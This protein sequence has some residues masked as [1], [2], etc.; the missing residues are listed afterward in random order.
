MT[1]PEEDAQRLL[2]LLE[3]QHDFPGPFMF[4]VIH[5]NEPGFALTLIEAVCSATGL[6]RPASEPRGRVSGGGRFASTTLDIEVRTA[7]DVLD[8]YAILQRMEHVIS[9]F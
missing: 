9:T 2:E 3:A 4:K 6:P 1:T 7:Q 5:K 8:V